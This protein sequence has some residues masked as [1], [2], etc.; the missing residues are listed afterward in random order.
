MSLR[1]NERSSPERIP[2]QN[3]ISKAVLDKG[4]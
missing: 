4:F 3:N 2:V 1:V